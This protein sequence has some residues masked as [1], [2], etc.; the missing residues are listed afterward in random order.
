[1]L[2][3]TMIGAPILTL[4]GTMDSG[5]PLESKKDS[6]ENSAPPVTKAVIG[7]TQYPQ[8]VI[9]SGDILYITRFISE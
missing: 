7:E 3:L 4:A 5:K 8:L 9:G 6:P 2:V 1:M